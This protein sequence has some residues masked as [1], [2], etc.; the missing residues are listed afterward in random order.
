[1]KKLT[2]GSAE[3]ISALQKNSATWDKRTKFSQ[4]KWLKKK[5]AKYQVVFEAKKPTAYALCELLSSTGPQKICHLRADSLGFLLNIAN[6]NTMTR[7]LVVESTKGL[8]VGALCER[9]VAYILS[10]CFSNEEQPNVLRP[11]T[12]ILLNYNF[13]ANTTRRVGFIH[14]SALNQNSADPFIKQVAISHK[15]QFNSCLIVSDEY[16]PVQIFDKIFDTL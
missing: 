14:A 6:L 10:V 16:H 13:C 5:Q 4:E 7:C 12:E 15:H 3:I 9:S 8:V 11:Q 2:S 1:M